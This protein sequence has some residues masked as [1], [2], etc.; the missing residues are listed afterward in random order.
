MPIFMAYLLELSM[1]CH[2]QHQQQQ[3]QHKSIYWVGNYITANHTEVSKY[4]LN[5]LAQFLLPREDSYMHMS[6]HMKSF[7]DTMIAINKKK[8]TFWQLPRH[9]VSFHHWQ[10][11]GWNSFG[12]ATVQ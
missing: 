5:E 9:I 7:K 6:Q 8:C 12:S 2:R 1:E 3:Q 10:D 4:C 11:L